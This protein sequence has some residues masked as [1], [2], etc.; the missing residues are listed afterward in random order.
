MLTI[1]GSGKSL[2]VAS[3]KD[4]FLFVNS[5]ILRS[6]QQSG[7][8]AIITQGML[9]TVDEFL[10]ASDAVGLDK[11]KSYIMRSS[12]QQALRTQNI[13]NLYVVTS[14]SKCF[15][16]FRLRELD[17]SYGSLQCIS[18]QVVA[19]MMVI[20]FFKAKKVEKRLL[21]LLFWNLLQSVF[22]LTIPSKY[23]PSTGGIAFLVAK[24]K[25]NEANI[26]L[27]GI[28]CSPKDAYYPNEKGELVLHQFNNV[29]FLA[30]NLIFDAYGV[31]MT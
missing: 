20:T 9:S 30:D 24:L 8:D 14:E 22:N 1:V 27:D 31:D 28:G 10:Q 18:R 13:H 16:E 5:A 15:V 11:D 19:R 3:K 2:P 12:K 17:V 26:K 23:R 29:H 21:T 6:A 4:R 7:I 25:K